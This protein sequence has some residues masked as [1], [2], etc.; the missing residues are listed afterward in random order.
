[1]S[2]TFRSDAYIDG[3]WRAGV[4]RF[5]V[6]NPAT[7]AV[8]AQVPDLGAAETEEAVVAAHRAFPAWAAKSATVTGERSCLVRAGVIR[9]C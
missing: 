6:F 1:M 7:Q 4:K 5:E 9:S 3:Q 2:L 8:I